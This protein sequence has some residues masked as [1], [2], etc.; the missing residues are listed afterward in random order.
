MMEGNSF[1]N[2]IY[3][4]MQ[5]LYSESGLRSL[6]DGLRKFCEGKSAGGALTKVAIIAAIAVVLGIVIDQVLYWTRPD[7]KEKLRRALDRCR[8]LF[9][10]RSA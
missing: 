6:L 7:Q 2:G 10:R 9:A 8:G 5:T 1:L 3:G 4:F